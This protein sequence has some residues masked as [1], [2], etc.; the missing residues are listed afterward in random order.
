[1]SKRR[2]LEFEEVFEELARGLSPVDLDDFRLLAELN[3]NP[4]PLA[5]I[6]FSKMLD[7]ASEEALNALDRYQDSVI[8]LKKAKKNTE[9]GIIVSNE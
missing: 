4:I 7:D 1:M 9:E 3:E 2:A 5:T 8:K 6:A